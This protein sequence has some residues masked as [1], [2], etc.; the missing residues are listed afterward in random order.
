MRSLA[1]AEPAAFAPAQLVFTLKME[2]LAT[3]PPNTQ[4]PI[5]FTAPNNINYTVRMTNSPTDYPAG[6]TTTA[7]LTHTPIFQYGPTAGPFVTIDPTARVIL[8]PVISSPTGQ[9][10][11]WCREAALAILRSDK[12]FQ[13]S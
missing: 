11:S 10:R 13:D 8:I 5:T 7:C 2:S 1:I 4:W 9:S 6:C 3:V 12:A